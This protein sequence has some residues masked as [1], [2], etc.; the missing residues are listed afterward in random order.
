MT[1]SISLKERSDICAVP[2]AAIVGE[3]VIAIEILKAIQ[4]K[5]GCD[6]IDEIKQ[7]LENYKEYIKRI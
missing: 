1:Q 5:F 2:S 4:E 6:N 3:A 7:N